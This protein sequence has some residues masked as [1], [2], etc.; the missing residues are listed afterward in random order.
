M[1]GRIDFMLESR[2]LLQFADPA[3]NAAPAPAA[4]E[5]AVDLT[6]YEVLV[7][8]IRREGLDRL[9]GDFLEI[10]CFLGGG[11]AKLAKVAAG[12]G[13]RV[14]VIDVFDPSLDITQNL[15]GDR[16]ADLYHGLLRGHTQEEIFQQVTAPWSGLIHVFK[17]DSMKVRLPDNLRFSFAFTDGNHSPQW[18]KSDFSLVWNR[19][20]PGGW[21]GFHD[22]G[23]DLP[24]VTAALDSMMA[25]YRAEIA[26]VARVEDRWI[27]LLQK[28]R[29]GEGKEGSE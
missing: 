9:P 5:L 18:V 3:F 23:G 4:V 13:K 21:A 17:E 16:M 11:T 6:G 24:E 20:A 12:A 22:Y 19:L 15:A 7:D 29:E 28:R 10:G 27:V 8:L 2:S 25:Q 26:R 1:G 14:W